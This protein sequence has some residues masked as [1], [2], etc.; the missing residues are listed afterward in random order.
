MAI[1][2]N[3]SIPVFW[4]PVLKYIS[5]PILSIIFSFAY[6][7]FYPK[8]IDPTQ[9][10]AFSLSH[11]VMVVIVIGIV[12]PRSLDI[13]VP[14]E[15]RYL[16]KPMYAPQ[17]VTLGVLSAEEAARVDSNNREMDDEDIRYDGPKK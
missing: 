2:K 8:R 14:P 13:F 11:I 16:G 4:A 15:K 17:V 6:P 5:A 1:G 3:W 9:I 12:I 10:F 7:A